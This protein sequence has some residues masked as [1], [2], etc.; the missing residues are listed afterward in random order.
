MPGARGPGGAVTGAGVRFF[1][2]GLPVPKGSGAAL[3]SRSTGKPFW[4]PS[5]SQ[6]LYR[7]QAS[8]RAFAASAMREA[9][10]RLHAGP[11][12]IDLHFFLPR[13]RRPRCAMP[14]VRP[15]IDKLAR[16]V[17]DALTGTCFDDDCRVVKA[18]VE[19]RW[20]WP[21]NG[22]GV[23]VHVRPVE[24]D[25]FATTPARHAARRAGGRTSAPRG[26]D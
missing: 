17:F 22:P 8:V 16:A 3:V 15:D 24:I 7:W 26:E 14:D 21:E 25:A 9:G 18:L 12:C 6:S 23:S 10:Q 20:E 2:A 4:K 13:P 5:R 19:K 11:V 1:A